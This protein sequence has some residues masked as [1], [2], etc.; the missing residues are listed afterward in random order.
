MNLSLSRILKIKS[1]IE[2]AWDAVGVIDHWLALTVQ[3]GFPE[4]S[5]EPEEYLPPA[6]A[7]QEAE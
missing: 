5:W 1:H 7:K 2:S 6:Q 4:H 3:Y